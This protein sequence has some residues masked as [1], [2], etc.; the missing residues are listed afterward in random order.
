VAAAVDGS[1]VIRARDSERVSAVLRLASSVAA[2]LG[3]LIGGVALMGWWLGIPFLY[4]G[5]PAAEEV[6]PNAALGLVL[7]CAAYWL[8]RKHQSRSWIR[9]IGRTAAG[10]VVVIA[11]ASAAEPVFDVD[12]R[13]A[14]ILLS[15]AG[16]TDEAARMAPNTAAGL[17]LLGLALLLLHTRAG[18]WW[19]SHGL[20]LAAGALG[21]L[22]LVG[23]STDLPSLY[24][25][26][27]VTGMSVPTAVALPLLALGLLLVRPDRGALQL[28]SSDSP[29]GVLARRLL[30]AAVL[31][32][33]A[34]ALLRWEGEA[35]GLYHT[36]TGVFLFTTAVIVLFTVAIWQASR[37]LDS[38]DRAARLAADTARASEL[39][40]EAEHRQ[41]R[42]DIDHFFDLS[43]DLLCIAGTDGYFKRL[44]PAWD[45]VFGYRDG[46]LL[47]QP[48]GSF[49][50]PDDVAATNAQVA[51][52]AGGA[53][54]ASFEN[55]YRCKDG[56]YRWLLW[57]T[58][59]LLERGLLY[60][61][62]R[63]ITERKNA[64]ES[65]AWLAAI[66]N[67][68]ADAIMG[69]NVDGIVTSWNR[70]A[71]RM[72]GYTTQEMC[73]RPVTRLAPTN[74]A[75]QASLLASIGR[76]EA[77]EQHETTRLRKDGQVIDVSLTLSPVRAP[78]GSVM[79]ASVIA[80]DITENRRVVETLRIQQEQTNSIIA[81]AGD[82]FVG[83]D[84]A[85]LITE[86]NRAAEK[87]FGW[88]RDEVVGRVLAEI[89]I[90]ERYRELHHAGLRRV[91]AGGEPQI[92]DR[93]IEIPALHRDGRE[94]LVELAVWCL[95]SAK[96]E[97][98]SAFIRDISQRKQIENDLAHA[99]DQALEASRLK[100]EFLAT[101]SHEIRTPMN[102]VIGLTG[103]LL[104]S[105]L[106][107]TQRRY[108]DG[109]HTSGNVLLSV[110]N[111]ILDFSKIEAGKLVLDD[112]PV[113]LR[114]LVD[115]VTELVADTARSKGLELIGYC[116]P[117]LPTSLRGDPV[118]L[119]QI[120]LNFATNAVKFTDRGEVLIQVR[121]G[122]SAPRATDGTAAS[123]GP[124]EVWLE[125]VDSGIGIA[126]KDRD[127]LFDAFAQVDASTT[128]RFGGTGLGLAICRELATAMG[129]QIGVD[130]RI[131]SGSTFWSVIPLHPA[132]ADEQPK[133]SMDTSLEGLRVLVVDDNDTNRLILSHQLQNWAMQCTTVGS[134]QQA[135][136]ELQSA[137]SRGQPYDLALLDTRMPGMDG[138][139][140]A[141][142]IRT[143]MGIAPLSLLLLTSD[144]SVP[145]EVVRD[146]GF[147]A[148]L[149]KPVSQSHLHDCLVRMVAGIAAPVR[150]TSPPSGSE[151][152]RGHLLL[153]EDNQ[154]N[155]L[156]ALG[157]LAGAGYTAD[158]A[159]NGLDALE[160][161]SRNSY[162][163]VLMDCQM[164]HMDGY[165][166][167]GEL[168]QREH[169]SASA[170]RTPIIAMTAAALEGDRERCLAAGM[171]DYI[172]KPV[173]PDE[174]AAVLARWVAA[175]PAANTAAPTR[176]PSSEQAIRDRLAE[177]RS[178][179]PQAAGDLVSRIVASFLDRS[180][181][182]L[183]DLDR[184]LALGDAAAFADA[185][186]SLNGAAGNLGATVMS[187]LCQELEVLSRRNDLHAVPTLMDQLRAEHHQVCEILHN[188]ESVP[189][190]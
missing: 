87:L 44:N 18:R 22:A 103:L 169:N 125:V 72:F 66:V 28:L 114:E 70:G 36:Q 149:M 23:H 171:D 184:N 77:L 128:R 116:D 43:L 80:R 95:T 113:N 127:R 110:I 173:Q 174:L 49:V 152:S 27:H 17:G 12:L 163:A 135:L 160:L 142:H 93:R 54:T 175:P 63:D 52:L 124:V 94:V 126:A 30:P 109:I 91:L 167:T 132:E 15:E 145:A 90:P 141:E 59:P 162:Q 53:M 177:L 186:H 55:R 14:W 158:V 76:S 69:M 100:S 31:L 187:A 117:S 33:V 170:L 151:P 181:T 147:A 71:E 97:R 144:G 75:D 153:V 79:G 134:G 41:A 139:E 98:F 111:D 74:S 67:S 40:A 92:L 2:S 190:A 183:V 156:V 34:L 38:A 189:A 96:T 118:R 176:I 51:R 154:I 112:A 121:P 61:V 123:T 45:V 146:A 83:M 99:R 133:P 101:M 89:L 88:P 13:I 32:P 47:T 166:A 157:L 119:R 148:C 120:L 9:V 105:T 19:P 182:Y 165:R 155:Q 81:T 35:R 82:A 84:A 188:L 150:S 122:P 20:A 57:N 185:A 1:G 46:E 5:E 159:D 62:A 58:V 48:F 37:Y 106:N 143:N 115:E 56:S 42:E 178:P 130:S 7:S 107:D 26:G 73:G 102:G 65:S 180:P 29:G 104:D 136:D 108:A 78:D 164:P 25:F 64:D 6:K 10:A 179:A 60:A 161:A 137:G 16:A 50:H 68:S 24:G 168:R 3:G 4:S 140:T 8:L 21:F 138:L 131:G 172:S 86:W 39:R 11:T 129:G 85:G